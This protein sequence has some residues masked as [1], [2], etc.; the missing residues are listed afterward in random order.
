MQDET[1][2]PVDATPARVLMSLNPEYYDLMWRQEKNHEF[3]RRYLTGRPTQWFVYLTVP[4]S[5]LT[6]VI[7]L[8]PAIVDTPAAIA[9]IAET[10]RPGNGASVRDYLAAKG[11]PTGCA[12]P[13]R[14]VREFE[15]FSAD[16]LSGMLDGFH[17][18]QGYTLVDRHPAWGPVCDKL[19]STPLVRE[20][21]IDTPSS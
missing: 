1:L 9:A 2:F 4:T 3:R 20:T 7:D 14:R 5:R 19:L 16:D 6:A 11:A 8:A 21:T 10:M 18:P 17:P 13:I 12:M 15:G